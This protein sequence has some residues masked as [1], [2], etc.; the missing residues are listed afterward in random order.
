[1]CFD[2][3]C[4]DEEDE[5]IYVLKTIIRGTNILI[6]IQYLH[7][8]VICNYTYIYGYIHILALQCL[9]VYYLFVCIHL[10]TC[11]HEFNVVTKNV[12][13]SVI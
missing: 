2:N 8:I 10:Y 3:I 13:S 9:N 4:R 1:M 11:S 5:G 7:I 6:H 12:R